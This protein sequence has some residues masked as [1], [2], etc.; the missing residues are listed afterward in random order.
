MYAFILRLC[1]PTVYYF[2]TLTLIAYYFD[3]LYLLCTNLSVKKFV[4]KVA[5]TTIH[6]GSHSI[7]MMP[8]WL[9]AYTHSFIASYS[10]ESNIRLKVYF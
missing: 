9:P 5:S 7:K 4:L 8:L 3:K 2:S 10:S 6:K 1:L